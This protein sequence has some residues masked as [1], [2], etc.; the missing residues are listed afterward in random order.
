[1]CF[2]DVAS[3]MAKTALEVIGANRA[4][5]ALSQVS[6]ESIQ[7]KAWV[8]N[9][10]FGWRDL[11][12]KSEDRKL[13]GEMSKLVEEAVAFQ[14]DRNQEIFLLNENTAAAIVVDRTQFSYQDWVI[15]QLKE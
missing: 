14:G 2:E 1:M 7:T 12:D 3:A 13:L 4:I 5:M 8:L 6:E 10:D 15:E 9:P 11:H